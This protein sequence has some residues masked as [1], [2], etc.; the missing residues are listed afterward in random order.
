MPLNRRCAHCGSMDTYY[1]VAELHC[2]E[3]GHLT[4]A[5]GVAV[6]LEVQHGPDW[7]GLLPEEAD[8]GQGS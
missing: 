8:D 7:P 2:N 1:T 5:N 6:P 3:C 4:D